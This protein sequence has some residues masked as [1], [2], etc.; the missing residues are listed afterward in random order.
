MK[1]GEHLSINPLGKVPSLAAVDADEDF[2]LFESQAIAS[3]LLDEFDLLDSYMHETSQLRARASMLSAF[4]DNQ[5]SPLNAALYRAM[6]T[7][8]RATKVAELIKQLNILE[9]LMDAEPYLV[10]SKLTLADIHL[11]GVFALYVWAGPK[12]FGFRPD[13][14]TA[15]PKLTAWY[16]TMRSEP[17]AQKVEGEVHGA[18]QA[19]LEAGRWEKMDIPLSSLFNE[20]V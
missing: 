3:F 10:S 13:D 9:Q 12:F 19:W 18:L 11:F 6:D 17:A 1:S 14:V 5:L 15:R 8:E 7:G 2:V 20:K 16:S 4:V